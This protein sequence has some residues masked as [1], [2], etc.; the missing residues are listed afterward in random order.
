MKVILTYLLLL[1]A[2]NPVFSQKTKQ[3]EQLLEAYDKAGKFSGTVLVAEKGKIIFEKS[4]GYRNGPK[5]EKNTN[6]SLYRIFSTT[7]MFTST[8]ILKLEE[9]GKLSIS[10]KLSKYYPDFPKGDSIT[11]ANLLSHTSGIPNE[12]GSENTVDEET[13]IKYISAK[14]L[15]FPP[16]TKWDYS[17][18]GYYILGYIIKKVTGMDYDKA[19]ESYILKP[20]QMNHTG[21]HFNTVT[22]ENKAF[23]YDFL[24]DHASTEAFRFKTDHPFAAGAMYSTVGD[25]FKFNESFKNN[26]ILEK[27]TT[28][29]MF[30]PYLNDHYGLGSDVIINNG[31]KS[32]GHG[33]GGPGY[34]SIY[35]KI[36]EDDICFIALSNST[37]SHT[38][39]IVPKIENIIYHKPYK[40][41]TAVK[42]N[43]QEL[44]KL[45]GIYSAGNTKF[46]VTVLDGQVLFRENG[47]PI[48]SLFPVS[49]TSFQ[50]DDN[51][52]FT[53]K[54]DETGKINSVMVK[55]RDGT[56]KTGTKTTDIYLWGII[57]DATPGGW[58]GKDT[59]LQA[60]TQ[61][62]NLYF[63]KN[64]H[65]KKG[66]LKF[67]LDNDW[68]YNLGLNNDGKTIALNAYDFLI[69]EEGQY[70]IL[71]D[72]SD[73]IKPQYN[74]KKS[75]Q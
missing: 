58:D 3:I 23:G 67:R 48:C 42:I 7:K 28:E 71:L 57:G 35:Y 25:L 26:T 66:K 15:N 16:N 12:T 33:G 20:L 2:A 13:F 22:D 14:P 11:I 51:V 17:N 18:S 55:L 10:D 63:L 19:I 29:K 32:V 21:F 54:P 53:F 69:G 62:P 70:D 1:L 59:P 38:D 73:P 65:L 5:K 30:T 41:P 50:L 31:K 68:G 52:T 61:K 46:Y 75:V 8:V 6:K 34:R 37:L 45:E 43:Q 4:Y 9:E 64:Y 72:M 44:K 56:V 36:L 27:E 60:D 49:N 39:I 40:I 47:Y 24:L 74:I